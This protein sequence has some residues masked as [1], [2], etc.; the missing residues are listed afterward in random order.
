MMT[1][2]VIRTRHPKRRPK[3]L[4]QKTYIQA[5]VTSPKGVYTDRKGERLSRKP[6]RGWRRVYP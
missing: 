2:P 4:K 3:E 5:T 6:H 1:K